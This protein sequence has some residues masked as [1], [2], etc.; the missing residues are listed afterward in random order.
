MCGKLSSLRIHIGKFRYYVSV[1]L[2]VGIIF[3]FSLPSF[4]AYNP[5]RWRFEYDYGKVKTEYYEEQLSILFDEK[6]IV[7]TA[8][9]HQF[10]Y[11]Y[12]LAPPWLDFSVGANITGTNIDDPSDENKQ[13]QYIS[14][15]ANLGVLI[16]ISYY[17]NVKL[18]TETF[19]TTMEVK[20]DKFGFRNLRG[21]QIYPE[22]EWLPFGTDMF[23]QLSPYLK[24]PLWSDTGNRKETTV[25]LKFT[26]P[27]NSPGEM[28]FP[29]FA[30]NT[31]VVIRLFYTNM[32]LDFEKSGFISSEFEVRQYGVT[33]GLN[34]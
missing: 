26:V 18:I 14:A 3:L 29:T 19:Y 22:I 12:Y 20:G 28:R 4:G 23:F 8:D 33:L 15:Y 5:P 6:E 27:I 30:Y 13:F 1:K 9:F 11:Q 7:Q 10:I 2:L 24:F 34:F 25:G 32:Q 21:T 31:S 17:W 16:P